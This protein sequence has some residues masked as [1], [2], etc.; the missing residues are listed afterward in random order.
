MCEVKLSIIV[1]APGITQNPITILTSVN[2]SLLFCT[3]TEN[4]TKIL[5]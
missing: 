5:T 2:T 1:F 3:L 4:K